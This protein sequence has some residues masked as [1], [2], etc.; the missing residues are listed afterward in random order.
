VSDV[1]LLTLTAHLIDVPSV[2]FHEGTLCDEVTKRL[3]AMSHL[4]VTRVGDNVVARTTLGKETRLFIGGHLD[5]VPAAGNEKAIKEGDRV[6]GLGASDMKGG[7]AVML[8]LAEELKN[9]NM[10]LT[11]CFYAREEVGRATSGLGELWEKAP[12]LLV[13]DAA[14]LC[15]PTDGY[16]EAGCQGT[17]RIR[18]TFGGVRAHSARPFM[19]RNAIHR[20]APFLEIMAKWTPRVVELDGCT[21]TEQLQA[22][23]IEGGVATNVVPDRVSVTINF[24]Y[25]PDRDGNQALAYLDDLFDGLLESEAGDSREVLDIADGAPPGLTH[26]LLAGLVEATGEAPKAKVGWTD[27]A[28]MWANGVPAA[29]FGPGDPLLAHSKDEWVDR[30]SLDRAYGALSQLIRGT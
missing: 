26:P 16:V 24:R 15:E 7:I 18:Y 21:Y 2:S 20:L 9:P 6:R 22:V 28:T 1:D 23:L 8:T 12:T 5:T 27:V 4:E 30:S 17:A 3:D 13:A 25:A 10:D 19:G 11:W 14:I 29:N